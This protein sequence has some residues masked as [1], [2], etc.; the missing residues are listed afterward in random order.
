MRIQGHSADD[1]RHGARRQQ[2]RVRE[3]AEEQHGRHILAVDSHAEVQAEFGAVTG[4]H[5]S[6]QLSA[7]HR[8][9]L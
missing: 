5:G 7:R 3:A 6:D 4:I 2:Y 8:F 9:A 1:G